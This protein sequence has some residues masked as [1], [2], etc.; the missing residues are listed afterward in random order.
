MSTIYLSIAALFYTILIAVVYFSKP[1]IKTLENKVYQYVILVSLLSLVSEI[2][3]M[4]IPSAK[5]A[6]LYDIM[7]KVYLVCCF[8]WVF[9]F[10]VYI[11]IISR[12]KEISE[13]TNQPKK[14]PI[15]CA[16]FYFF[17]ILIIMLLPIYFHNTPTE[18][19][20]YG[21]SVNFVF[22]IVG[23]ALFITILFLMKH[24]KQL[25][26]KKYY[27][28][29]FFVILFIIIVTIQ[30]INPS[31]LLV[32]SGLSFITA[33]MYFT[34]ENPDIKMIQ[35]LN[36]ARETAEKAN[37]AKS[38]FLSS[39][40]HEIRTPLNAIVGLSEDIASHEDLPAEIADEA[41]DIVSASHTLLEIVGNILDINKIE[42]N[43]M[44]VTE[45]P[46]H[47]KEEITELAKIDGTRI[48]E[49]P[50]E[51]NI[52]IAEDIPYELLGDKIHIKQIVNNLLTNAIK[53]TDQG[54]IT[55]NARCINQGNRCLLILTCQDTGKGIKAENITKLFDKFERL[56]VEKTTTTEGT[57]LGLAITKKLV[58]MMGGTINVQSQYGKGS[59]FMVQI[60]QKISQLVNPTPTTSPVQ[61]ES[62]EV[63]E[64]ENNY[65]GKRVLIVDDNQLNIK[66][67]KVALKDFQF[68]L[69]E[70]YSGKEALEKIA[71][72]EKYDLILMDIMM[73]EMSGEMTM[74]ELKKIVGFQTPVIALTA[75]AVS[76]AKERYLEAGF[77]DYVAKPF[78]KAIIKEKIDQIF[79][80]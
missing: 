5:Y 16:G 28:I 10:L 29:I 32:N 37:H 77:T 58:E 12:A 49:K 60:P 48:G 53:Y 26:E 15:V 66:V 7:L 51:Y 54:S 3:L 69:D 25:K 68:V 52:H 45:V 18:K 72:G 63:L 24:F 76:G 4:I 13:K 21:P 62:V 11:Y 9:I 2:S 64:V 56:G 59:I 1:R 40:S 78:T 23:T 19:Y 70:C 50:I 34:I 80:S 22:T 46:Y 36:I 75:D 44:E 55:F 8:S 47:F 65:Q 20:S 14:L 38:D 61:S 39:M 17:C 71:H 67:A 31:L 30:K 27:P 79:S 43:K 6:V 42:S 33:L 41:K 57:G 35:Q 74:Q 73:P